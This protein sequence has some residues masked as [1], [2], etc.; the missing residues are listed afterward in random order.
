MS[1]FYDQNPEYNQLNRL[2]QIVHAMRLILLIVV[3]FTSLGLRAEDTTHCFNAIYSLKEGRLNE[4][5]DLYTRCINEGDL[6]KKNMI[7]ALND[8]GN[9]FGKNRQLN[10]ALQDFS[11]LIELD[12]EDPDAYYKRGLTLKKLGRPEAALADYDKT[13]KLK[14]RYAKAY[15]NR[16]GLYGAQGL[17]THAITDFNQ[18]IFLDDD[19]AGAHFNRGLAY[20]SQGDYKKAI[21]DLERA[22]ELDPKYHKAYEN[23]AWLRA[24]CP[25]ESLRDGIMAIALAKKARFLQPAGTSGLYD[26]LAAASAA[27]GK[28][29]DAVRY[30]QMAIETAEQATETSPMQQRLELYE[31]QDIYL[32]ETINRFEITG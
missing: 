32:D 16:G 21:A 9:A 11:Q 6:T 13:I 28:Y 7:V 10:L 24:T 29:D 12:P 15:N 8:R 3:G 5:I 18:A 30:Q 2:R 23:L 4:A 27:A 20:Y 26:I 19:N 17:F 22:I 25:V 14:P 1:S 31:R